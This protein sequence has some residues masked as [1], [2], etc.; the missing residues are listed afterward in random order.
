MLRLYDA[1]ALLEVTFQTV[2]VYA[3]CIFQMVIDTQDYNGELKLKGCDSTKVF[4]LK[5]NILY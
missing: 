2:T 4:L 5:K 1:K 3:C